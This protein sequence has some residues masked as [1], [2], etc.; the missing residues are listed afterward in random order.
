M[1]FRMKCHQKQHGLNVRLWV[2]CNDNSF[3]FVVGASAD[4][5]CQEATSGMVL[6]GSSYFCIQPDV[7]V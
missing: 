3:W 6:L 4:S 1:K 7:E 5:G 2:C